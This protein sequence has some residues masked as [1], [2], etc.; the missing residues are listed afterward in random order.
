MSVDKIIKLLDSIDDVLESYVLKTEIEMYLDFD[1]FNPEIKVKIYKTS[2]HDDNPYKFSVSHHARTPIQA[3]PYFP[4]TIFFSSEEE[5][6]KGAI[7]STTRYIKMAISEGHEPEDEWL[8]LN[9]QF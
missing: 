2:T 1:D 9:D 5:A 3:A 4:S 6:I 8:V 7:S